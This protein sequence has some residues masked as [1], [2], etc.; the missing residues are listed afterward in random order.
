MSYA[1]AHLLQVSSSLKKITMKFSVPGHS[2]IQEVD[3]VHS[4]IERTLRKSEYSS[5]ISLIRILLSVN[6][7]KPYNILQMREQDFFDFNYYSV[8][9]NYKSVP[10]SKVVAL[11]F[12]KSF[13]E[14]RY[15]LSF[16][17][18]EYRS[19]N[20][21]QRIGRRQSHV[22]A[23][24]GDILFPEILRKNDYAVVLAQHKV[25][26]IKS[27]FKWMPKNDVTFYETVF[28][29]LDKNKK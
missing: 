17:E 21:R 1:I 8:K 28:S 16:S 13:Y 24:R 3:S 5:P 19:L 14:I 10:F 18:A 6:S 29:R 4:A 7:K 9:M 11:E 27:M 26:A 22:T 25:D 23:E 2:C 15:R 12:N 20:L